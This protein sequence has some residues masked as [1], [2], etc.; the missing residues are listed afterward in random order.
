MSTTMV[1]AVFSRQLLGYIHCNICLVACHN[2]FSVNNNKVFLEHYDSYNVSLCM[3]HKST[4]ICLHNLP[5]WPVLGYILECVLQLKIFLFI[6]L[7]GCASFSCIAILIMVHRIVTSYYIIV[8]V[9]EYK[10]CIDAWPKRAGF[11]PQ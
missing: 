3:V 7:T 6:F 9:S 2:I 1:Y 8:H 10:V 5:T 11:Y 4:C